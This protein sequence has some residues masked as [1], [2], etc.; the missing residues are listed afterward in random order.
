MALPYLNIDNVSYSTASNVLSVSLTAARIRGYDNE[1]DIIIEG[2]SQ[3]KTIPITNGFFQGTVTYSLPDLET[4]TSSVSSTTTYVEA[5]RTFSFTGTASA[6]QSVRI[7]SS[8]FNTNLI[9]H[10]FSATVSTSDAVV[11][12]AA[13]I[14]QFATGLW[15]GFTAEASNTTLT[16]K[17]PWGAYYNGLDITAISSTSSF[18][19][20]PTQSELREG[21]TNYNLNF[22]RQNPVL[23]SLG[24]TTFAFGVGTY[25]LDY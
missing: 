3:S 18:V 16:V 12:L 25:S 11:I 7:T 13:T 17:A 9:L 14:S 21:F 15:A 23:G 5:S 10:T 8:D 1:N 2:F 4:S 19:V 6:G 20:S 24:I 22:R